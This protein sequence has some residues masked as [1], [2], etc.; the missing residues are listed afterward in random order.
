MSN[1]FEGDQEPLLGGDAPRATQAPP[2]ATQAAPK[3]KAKAKAH[4]AKA[5]AP[6][7]TQA[8]AV[9]AVR[10]NVAN[11]IVDDKFVLGRECGVTLIS[12]ECGAGIISCLRDYSHRG[13]LLSQ[14][15]IIA[16]EGV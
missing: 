9:A 10:K 4:A 2:R 1:P 6:V 14:R 8:A 15:E 7:H 11:H 3:A 5:H 13:K 12:F 16:T